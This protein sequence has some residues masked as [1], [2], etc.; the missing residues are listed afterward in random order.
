VLDEP[1]SNLDNEG[2]AA[3]HQAILDLKAREPLSC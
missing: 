1:N 3:L 2:D